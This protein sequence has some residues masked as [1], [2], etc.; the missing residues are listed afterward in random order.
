M[1]LHAQPA[2]CAA[3]GQARRGQP[4]NVSAMAAATRAVHHS[5]GIQTVRTCRQISWLSMLGWKPSVPCYTASQQDRQT[6]VRL[7]NQAKR[8]VLLLEEGAAVCLSVCLSDH[9]LVL[10]FATMSGLQLT[11]CLSCCLSVICPLACPS[12]LRIPCPSSVHPPHGLSL[13]LL[14]RYLLVSRSLCLL[15]CLSVRAKEDVAAGVQVV[16]DLIIQSAILK[17]N[18]TQLSYLVCRIGKLGPI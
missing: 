4:D 2:I 14:A 18:R 12:I 6:D 3:A 16:N 10:P 17:P 13:L 1:A 15:V 11:V 8:R 9:E 5:R 7:G